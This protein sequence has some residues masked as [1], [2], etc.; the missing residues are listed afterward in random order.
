MQLTSSLRGHLAMF[1]F[2][3]L[4]AGAFSLG[5]LA[6]PHVAPEALNSARFLV[7]GSLLFVALLATGQRP[8]AILRAPW[9]F[10]ILGGLMVI[11]F[12]TM[13]EGLKTAP[14]VNM[15]SV[16]T[17]TPA[18][19]AVFGLILVRQ[20][21]TPRIALALCIGGAGA[22]W[23]IF[24]ADMAAL[25]AFEVGDGEMIFFFG[26]A[27]HAL[28]TP[29]VPRLNRGESPM[30]FTFGVL[31]ASGLI[32]PL[33]GW[34]AI[35]ATDWANLPAIVWITIGY[36]SVVASVVTFVLLQYA[37]LRLP[38]SKVMAYTYLTPSWVILWEVA[39]GRP[40]PGIG[41]VA[42]VALT[43]VALFLLLKDETPAAQRA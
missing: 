15:S 25:M 28:Y 3:V 41:V 17:L 24:R 9:R 35:F 14:A 11:Y 13:F 38:S 39:Q 12:V 7:A 10:A 6:A 31:V 26:C 37:A 2:S 33:F 29:M 18:L 19:S 5:S 22:V 36:T 21:V 34:R 20:I 4:I 1:C 8:A 27:C 32:L 30:V 23:V 43:A 40:L 42:G 16:F